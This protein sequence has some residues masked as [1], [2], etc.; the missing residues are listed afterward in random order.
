MLPYL[1]P[2]ASLVDRQDNARTLHLV[3]PNMYGQWLTEIGERG[4]RWLAST[5][6]EPRPN[7]VGLFPDTDGE[8]EAAVVVTHEPAELWDVA[9]A[10]PALPSGPWLIKGDDLEAAEAA[11]AFAMQSYR[12]T[13]YRNDNTQQPMLVIGD[14]AARQRARILAKSI[15]MARDLVNTPTNDLGPEQLQAAVEFVAKEGG[16]KIRA[17]VG[18]E[19]IVQNYPTIHAVGR[20]SP[21]PPR[22][23]DLTWG[24]PDA[25]KVTLIGKGVCF[26]TGGLDIKP[27]SSMLLMRKDMAGAALMLALARS[28]MALALKVR[29]R[30]LIPAVE[31]SI[32]GNA[33][34]PGDILTTRKGLSVEIGNTDAEGRLILADALAD[35]DDETPDIILDA[36]TLTGAARVAI[37]PDLPALFSP[38]DG[39]ASDILRHGNHV[40]EPLWRLPLHAPYS[41]YIESPVADLNNAGTKPFAGSVTAALFLQRFLTNTPNWAHLDIFGWNDESRPGRPRG[42]EATAFR[43]LLSFLEE[44][45]G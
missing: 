37:G 29:L 10:I 43:A 13:R 34:R 20:A 11:L 39:L 23:L 26:D 44:R 38:N 2:L 3:R 28:I 8:L 19:L 14:A 18:E 5:G 24:A 31:N 41:R 27:S 16:A 32:A 45:Y 9:A 42:G 40:N 21:S 22:L 30:L 36:A 17:V 12:F 33:F 35:A 25:P 7:N 6:F 15:Y 1:T 4:R